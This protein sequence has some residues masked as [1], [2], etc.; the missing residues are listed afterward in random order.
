MYLCCNFLVIVKE[1]W[2]WY[3]Y[4]FL[5]LDTLDTTIYDLFHPQITHQGESPKLDLT[6]LSQW[7][8]P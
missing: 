8:Q 7:L 1:G 6:T 2:I 5:F 4:L 3:T